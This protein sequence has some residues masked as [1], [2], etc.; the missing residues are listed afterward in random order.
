MHIILYFIH[1]IKQIVPLE[2]LKAQKKRRVL[3]RF[4]EPMFRECQLPGIGK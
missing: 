4:T 3:A 2:H 1:S